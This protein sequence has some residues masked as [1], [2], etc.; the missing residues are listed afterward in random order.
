VSKPP[1]R[2]GRSR[3]GLGLF[4]NKPFRK[5]E[6]IVRYR[7]PLVPNPEAERMEARG[8]RYLFEINSRWTIDGSSRWNRARYVNHSCRPNA[9]AIERR[10]PSIV[11]VARRRIKSDEEITVDYGK[12]YFWSFIGKSRC[13]CD[14]CR[15]RRAERQAKRRARIKRARAK[16]SSRKRLKRRQ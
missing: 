13:R 2:V 8:S 12:D 10:G 1:Y 15:E 11:Y 5:R 7:G 14:K 4:A 6:Y 3:T 9:E 16:R